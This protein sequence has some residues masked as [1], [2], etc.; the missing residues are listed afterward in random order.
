MKLNIEQ[1]KNISLG[2]ESVIETE[3]GIEFDRFNSEERDVYSVSTIEARTHSPA[4]VE[5]MFKTDAKSIYISLEAEKTLDRSFFSVDILENDK[6]AGN[7]KNFE[8]EHMTGFYSWDEYPLG[9]FDGRVEFGN[10]EKEIR[11]VLPWSVRCY[12]KEINLEGATYITPVKKEKTMLF[13]GDSITHGYDSAHPLNTYAKRVAD[14]L[15]VEGFVK[16]VG[17]E[18]FLPDLARVNGGHNPDYVVIAYGTNDWSRNNKEQFDKDSKE[19][20]N[21]ISAN[22]PYAKIFVLTPIWRKDSVKETDS[23]GD[24]FYVGKHLADI[25]DGLKNVHLIDGWN[26]VSHNENLY[27]DLRLH[28]NDNGFKEYAKN[29]LAEIKEYI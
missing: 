29:L 17:G 18:C 12:F 13:Y 20:I 1:L 6:L 10:G 28:P 11:V 5:L 24:I 26:L 3:K 8:E 7:I 25:C 14:G 19:F 21:T 23:F 4:G 9:S 15:G 2:A 16:A 22:Y 27:G